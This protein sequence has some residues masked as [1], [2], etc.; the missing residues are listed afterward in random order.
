MGNYIVRTILKEQDSITLCKGIFIIPNTE[1]SFLMNDD[2]GKLT[3]RIGKNHQ[4][5][6]NFLSLLH[7]G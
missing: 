1:I 2:A 7:S 5:T 4:P 3:K 6:G